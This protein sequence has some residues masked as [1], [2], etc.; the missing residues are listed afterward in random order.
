MLKKDEAHQQA[1]R[2]RSFDHVTKQTWH[3]AGASGNGLEWSGKN[4]I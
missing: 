4:H 3:L 1:S 2:T